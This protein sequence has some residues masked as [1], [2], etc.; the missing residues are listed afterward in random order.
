[1]ME[2]LQVKNWDKWQSYRSDRGTPPWIK[3]H[4]KIMSSAT[5]AALE[6]IDKGHLI[7]IW[8]VAADRDGVIPANPAV[9]RKICQIDNQPDVNKFIDLGFLVPAKRQGDAKVT[10]IRRQVDPPETETEVETETELKPYGPSGDGPVDENTQNFERLWLK[11][12]RRAGN[13]PKRDALRAFNA[14]IKEGEQVKA[15]E[16][17]LKRYRLF[18]ERTGKI[19]TEKVQQF[20]TFLGPSKNYLQD[21]ALPKRTSNISDRNQD[22]IAAALGEAH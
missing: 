22:V 6:D 3:V 19:Q 14:R 20:K 4:R 1:M 5:W 7:S 10:S 13:D 2:Y 8:I 16:E 17:G 18:C 12:P 21:W 11:R 15:I 9:L